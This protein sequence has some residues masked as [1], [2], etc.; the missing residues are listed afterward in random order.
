VIGG[1]GRGD[2]KGWRG[3]NERC[4]VVVKS[5]KRGRGG[6]YAAGGG[7]GGGMA[8]TEGLS[9]GRLAGG[10]APLRIG[11]GGGLVGLQRGMLMVGNTPPPLP[12]LLTDGVSVRRPLGALNDPVT[13]NDVTMGLFTT[14]APPPSNALGA[15][16]SGRHVRRRFRNGSQ[17]LLHPRDASGALSIFQPPP[18]SRTDFTASRLNGHKQAALSSVFQQKSLS[19]HARWLWWLHGTAEK[20]GKRSEGGPGG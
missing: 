1:G 7:A 6:G 17:V 2:S 18:P 19:S 3:D 20:G 9:R 12:Q 11:W 4:A 14:T 10:A 13:F 8:A 15:R 16:A 5:F